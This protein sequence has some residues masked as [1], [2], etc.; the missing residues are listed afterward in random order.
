MW[1]GGG[2]DLNES[3]LVEVRLLPLYLCV[4]DWHAREPGCMLLGYPAQ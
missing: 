2:E 1:G 3:L 4:V